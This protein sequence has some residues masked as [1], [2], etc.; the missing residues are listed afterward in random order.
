MGHHR[1]VSVRWRARWRSRAAARVGRPDFSM[2]FQSQ[3]Y[4]YT[5]FAVTMVCVSAPSSVSPSVSSMSVVAPLRRSTSNAG[6][7]PLASNSQ[8][9]SSSRCAS[10][11]DRWAPAT[12]LVSCRRVDGAVCA[13]RPAGQD[14]L[15]N[16]CIS[17]RRSNSAF[18]SSSPTTAHLVLW[19]Q[20][21]LQKVPLER[22]DV[23]TLPPLGHVSTSARDR[24]SSQAAPHRHSSLSQMVVV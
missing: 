16:D 9:P 4:A 21:A 18:D 20:R 1:E 10:V 5:P 3:P 17:H 23:V 22:P 8:P 19:R 7:T 14:R 2:S 12:L 6:N 24:A 15:N 11:G 13:V